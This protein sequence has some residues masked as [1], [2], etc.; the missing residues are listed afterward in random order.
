MVEEAKE[1]APEASQVLSFRSHDM[2]VLFSLPRIA[3]Y[4]FLALHSELLKA[5]H[6][7]A[8]PFTYRLDLSICINSLLVQI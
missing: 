7:F 4:Y 5:Q 6:M 1:K 8:K 3:G 2:Q